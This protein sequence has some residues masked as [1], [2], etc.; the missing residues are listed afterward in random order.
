MLEYWNTA[1]GIKIWHCPH[2]NQ[3]LLHTFRRYAVPWTPNTEISESNPFIF[4]NY[5]NGKILNLQYWVSFCL[6]STRVSHRYIRVPASRTFLPP[7]SPDYCSLLFQSTG[8]GCPAS[9]TELAPVICLRM[10]MYMSQCYSL[11]SSHHCP[12]HRAPKSVLSISVSF[13]AQHVGS[14]WPSLQITH[15][16]IAT[17]YLYFSF[18]LYFIL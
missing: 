10:V 14:L 3:T 12:L 16:C 15:I 6:T 18:W 2:S 13:A 17:Q 4:L 11:K 5:F 7:H 9:C 8:F 1:L